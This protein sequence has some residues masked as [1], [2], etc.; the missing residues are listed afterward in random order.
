MKKIFSIACLTI[1]A[2][3]SLSAQ[4]VGQSISFNEETHDFGVIEENG[5]KVSNKFEFTNTGS[6]PLV[7]NNVKASCG[8]TTPEWSKEPVPAGAKGYVTATFDPK[9]R[10]GNFNKSITVTYA[11]SQ[12]KV[13]YIKGEV[14]GSPYPRSFGDLGLKTDNIGFAKVLN[15]EIKTE[16]IEI[17]N[18]SKEKDLNIKFKE[19]PDY[20]K[21]TA[22]PASLRPAQT[23][24]IEIAFDAKKKND[25]GF[26]SDKIRVIIND[27]ETQQNF[28]RTSSTIEEDFSKLTE[29]DIAKA[30]KLEFVTTNFDF[31][32][33]NQGE[34]I[35]TEFQFKNTGKSDLIIR[36][37]KTSSGC[38]VITPSK[39]I[40]KSGAEST[41]KASFNSTGKRGKQHQTIIVISN[42]PHDNGKA[43]SI[44]LTLTGTVNTPEENPQNK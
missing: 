3:W 22:N 11:E 31:G 9:N 41:M 7:I 24:V 23:G 20:I 15:T 29:S 42:D 19:V 14:K 5:G 34:T 43:S 21:V 12:T 10:P 36:N 1:F 28:I 38:T 37:T 30:P 32:T 44:T 13:L 25:W 27:D 18:N 33:I 2:C 40:I 35:S 39:N 26:F 17:I 8:C 16:K 4:Q 6:E